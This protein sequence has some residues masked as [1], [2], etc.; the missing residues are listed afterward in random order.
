MALTHPHHCPA[1]ERS[2]PFH[3]HCAPHSFH[4]YSPEFSRRF[5]IKSTPCNKEDWK[6]LVS[7]QNI[8]FLAATQN[9]HKLIV[10][11][12]GSKMSQGFGYSLAAFHLGKHVF[13]LSVPFALHASNFDAEMYALAHASDFVH[14][15]LYNCSSITEVQFYCDASSALDSIFDPSPHPAQDASILFR[16]NV[17]SILTKYPHVKITLTWTPGHKGTKGM[18]LVDRL[19]KK[20][21]KL[22]KKDR[23]LTFTSHSS[24]LA[25][26]NVKTLSQWKKHIK[27]HP[28]HPELG[29]YLVSG[30]W[31]CRNHV[32]L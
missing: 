8:S 2:N 7:E 24:A 18:D 29:F 22:K 23:L 15:K 16:V 21:A 14:R 13:S 4:W 26:L 12:D 27:D 31:T 5:L 19:A 28:F 32:F 1:T 30:N 25:A 10:F 3:S 17:Y 6:S 9:K 20:G 11:M